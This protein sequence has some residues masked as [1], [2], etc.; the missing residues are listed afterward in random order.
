[1]CPDTVDTLCGWRLRRQPRI[2]FHLETQPFLVKIVSNKAMFGVCLRLTTYRFLRLGSN[3]NLKRY[4]YKMTYIHVLCICRTETISITNNTWKTHQ[5]CNF[6]HCIEHHFKNNLQL[7]DFQWVF[8][9]TVVYVNVLCDYIK[10]QLKYTYDVTIAR[11]HVTASV[12]VRTR[13]HHGTLIRNHKT[14]CNRTF[15]RHLLFHVPMYTC[16]SAGILLNNK[17]AFDGSTFLMLYRLEV[18]K[19]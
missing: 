6:S 14:S 11:R 9:R 17:I 4:N 5:H 7:N 12:K 3:K 10:T 1:M 19:T 18:L 2:T 16:I 13:A 15:V 8:F